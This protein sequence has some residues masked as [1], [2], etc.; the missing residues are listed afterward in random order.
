[1]CSTPSLVDRTSKVSPQSAPHPD[2][3]CPSTK[4]YAVNRDCRP[5]APTELPRTP[6]G[7]RESFRPRTPRT[8][9]RGRLNVQGPESSGGH[10]FSGSCFETSVD[11]SLRCPSP[12]VPVGPTVV[13]NP[14]LGPPSLGRS[15]LA[16]PR[17]TFLL[18][19]PFS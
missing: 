4:V 10:V 13:R 8:L 12:V 15:T 18:F 1:M 19:V 14:P 17:W 5:C 16:T 9:R 7:D 6:R 3:T 2:L 11:D